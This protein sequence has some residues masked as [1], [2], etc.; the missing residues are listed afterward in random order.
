MGCQGSKQSTMRFHLSRHPID[1]THNCSHKS[2]SK[3]IIKMNSNGTINDSPV[4]IRIDEGEKVIL[5]VDDVRYMHDIIE[6]HI[7][8]KG[9]PFKVLSALSGNEAIRVVKEIGAS[10]INIILMDIVMVDGDGYYASQEIRKLGFKGTIVGISGM[11]DQDSVNKAYQYGMNKI[12]S[13][14]IELDSL[15]KATIQ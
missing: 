8:L 12:C 15:F 9:Y 5:I 4:R 10:N 1:V 7:K 14:P 3:K 13:K 6:T 11:V 2:K